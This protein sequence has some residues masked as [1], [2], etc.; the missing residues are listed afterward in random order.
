MRSQSRPA[1]VLASALIV[2]ACGSSDQTVDGFSSATWATIQTLSPLPALPADS[3]N[4]FADEARAA[5]FGQRLFFEKTYSGPLAV[6]NDGTNGGLGS[7]G[8]TGKVSCAS[9]HDASG[10]FLDDRSRPANTSLGAGWMPRRAP[11]LVDVAFYRWFGWAGRFDTL[12][13]AA[14]GCVENEEALASSRLSLDHVIYA[15][16]RA[17]YD[18]VFPTPID[19][20]LDPTAPDA[21][22][23]PPTG[24]PKASPT[25][26]DGPWETMTPA[27]QDIAN[28]IFANAGK[29][30]EAYVRLLTSRNTPFDRYVAGDRAAISTQAKQGLGLFA[31]KAACVACHDG[32]FMTDE[33][34]HVTGVGQDD[35]GPHAPP[36][37]NG[38]SD[39]VPALLASPFNSS[40]PYSDDRSSALL[41][42]VSQT[43]DE[44]GAFRT[45]DLRH[46][47][48]VGPYMHA[49]QYAGL[50]DV[51]N[52]YNE[53]GDDPGH[54]AGTKD[55]LM[56]PLN[57]SADEQG[58][59]VAF[60][61][62]LTG[63]AMPANL[64]T[65]T[66]AP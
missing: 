12:W 37:D 55:P 6:G 42:G 7:A 29:A 63:D 60:L 4:A 22:R 58:A 45:K 62:T 2:L 1:I 49:G 23:F 28:R 64:R 43:P 18:A 26:P 21:S 14:I 16:Y 27:D 65:D 33:K 11:S 52:F 48:M 46:A 8:D 57:L 35:G 36:M 61:Q 31:G 40:G 3:T 34:F 9:C 32:P 24:M 15:K 53:G 51:A 47:A 30:L 56:V 38:R 25:A 54:Y 44:L 50:P 10:W 39:A 41:R 5:A 17:D 59:I 66:S 20:A 19:P 13:S